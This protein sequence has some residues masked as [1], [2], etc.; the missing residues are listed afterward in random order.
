MV[1]VLRM[2]SGSASALVLVQS[3]VGSQRSQKKWRQLRKSIEILPPSN[4]L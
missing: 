4:E 3:A 2:R 1:S